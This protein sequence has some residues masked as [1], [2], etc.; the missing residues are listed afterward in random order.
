MTRTLLADT[1]HVLGS[2]P[3]PWPFDGRLHGERLALLAVQAVGAPGDGDGDGDLS[4]LAPLAD[5]VRTAGGLVVTVLA[6]GA[7]VGDGAG[8]AAVASDVSVRCPGRDGFH[9][10]ALDLLLRRARRDQLLLAGRHL[11]IEVHSTLRSANDRGYECLTVA[12]ACVAAEPALRAAALSTIQMSGGIFGAVGTTDHL[13]AALR[14]EHFEG[15][16]S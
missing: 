8:S 15:D 11:E 14:G 4:R 10:T 13:C 7:A 16:D 3:Y 12:D 2:T 6:G 5:A 1:R 9:G